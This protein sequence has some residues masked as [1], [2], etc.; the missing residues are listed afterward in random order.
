M[1]F[2]RFKVPRKPKFC[3]HQ[4]LNKEKD[5]KLIVILGDSW[6]NKN[7]FK[8]FIVDG[9][10][11]AYV[12]TRPH[13][14]IAD[15]TSVLGTERITC[16]EGVFVSFLSKSGATLDLYLADTKIQETWARDVPEV[17]VLHTQCLTQ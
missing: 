1:A 12:D 15:V 16:S 2:C 11:R 10:P 14:T 3:W 9:N 13:A 17:T 4:N 7:N 6:T 5:V 8:E